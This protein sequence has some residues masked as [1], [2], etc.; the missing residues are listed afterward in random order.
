MRNSKHIPAPVPLRRCAVY[1]RKSTNMGM[2]QNYTSIDAQID[3]CIQYVENH[4]ADGWVL[5][6][7]ATCGIYQDV[8]ISGATME[9]PGV[10]ALLADIRAKRV[11]VVVCYI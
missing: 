3:S 7:T 8:A 4:A 9:R 11:D 1:V 10:Q 6:Q 2:E 5:A